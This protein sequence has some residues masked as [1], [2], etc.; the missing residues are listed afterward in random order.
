MQA[1]W[2]KH[3]SGFLNVDEQHIFVT[4]TGNWSETAGLNEKN[5]KCFKRKNRISKF[6]TIAFLALVAA[7]VIWLMIAEIMNSKA[8]VFSLISLPVFY[9]TVHNYIITGYA[10]AYAIPIS[11]ITHMEVGLKSI[12]IDYSDFNSNPVSDTFSGIDQQGIE[13]L[14]QLHAY[15]SE[16]SGQV[17]DLTPTSNLPISPENLRSDRT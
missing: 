17:I 2:L 3:N 13:F 1:F 12:T 14:D 8:G 7:G 11:K 16:K 9:F 10:A 5:H 15:W 6:T 4:R